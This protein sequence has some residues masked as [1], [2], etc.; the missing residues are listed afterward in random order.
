MNA[1][2][3]KALIFTAGLVAV[4]LTLARGKN[5]HAAEST[6]TRT[7]SQLSEGQSVS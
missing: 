5:L 7:A 2:L 4:V 1:R 6:I 3:T